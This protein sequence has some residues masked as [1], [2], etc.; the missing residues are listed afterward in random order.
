VTQTATDDTTRWDAWQRANRES[1]RRS[2]VH[3]RIVACIMM[4]GVAGWLALALVG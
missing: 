4:V 1:S 3:A 2:E